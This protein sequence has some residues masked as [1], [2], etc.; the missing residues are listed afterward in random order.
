MCT[1]VSENTQKKSVAVC[2]ILDQKQKLE[3][4]I[5]LWFVIAKNKAQPN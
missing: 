5:M 2:T 4:L 3:L 1:Y